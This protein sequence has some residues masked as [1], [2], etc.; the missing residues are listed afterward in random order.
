MPS[1]EAEKEQILD[2][3]LRVMEQKLSGDSPAQARPAP[4]IPPIRPLPRQVENNNWLTPTLLDNNAETE[5][6]PEDKNPWITQELERQKN[7]Q[8]EKEALVKEQKLIDQQV[9]DRLQSTPVSP[10]NTAD[11]YRRSLQDILS[12]SSA[13]EPRQMPSQRE[14]R[15]PSK[16]SNPFT[17]KR[18][19]P[20]LFPSKSDSKTPEGAPRLSGIEPF[21]VKRSTLKP[22][23]AFSSKRDKTP[24][25]LPPLKRLRKSSLFDTD[26]FAD[27]DMPKINKSIWD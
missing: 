21:R 1:A 5:G 26:P 14:V 3:K 13:K 27:D 16:E 8:L 10:F 25:P 17:I 2:A 4:R 18:S 15:A 7:R 19:S 11:N 24:K 23:S 22:S 6:L 20:V 9:N 12:G